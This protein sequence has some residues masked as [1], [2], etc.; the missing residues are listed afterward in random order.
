MIARKPTPSPGAPIPADWT[1]SV[2]RLLNETYA[3]ECKKRDRYFDVYGRVFPEELLVVASFAPENRPHES[4]VTCFLSCDAAEM[5]DPATVKKTQ[6]AFVE[7]LGL[8]YDEI[9]A[10]P[11]WDEWEPLWQEVEHAGKTYFYRLSRENFGLTLE[12]DRLL[13][14]AGFDPEDSE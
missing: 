10:V 9:L 5:Q 4:A 14:E 2:A 12:A 7:L 6:A 1:E 11:E 3:D 13:R 8:F